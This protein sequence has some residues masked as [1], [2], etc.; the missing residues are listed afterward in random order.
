MIVFWISNHDRKCKP[1]N[2][3]ISQVIMKEIQIGTIF[4]ANSQYA[5]PRSDRHR[6]AEDLKTRLTAYNYGKSLQTVKFKPWK[7][8]TDL[9]FSDESKAV[10]FEEYLK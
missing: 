3:I 2:N 1:K 4:G 9:A 5:E 6:F 7:L 8:L 10:E